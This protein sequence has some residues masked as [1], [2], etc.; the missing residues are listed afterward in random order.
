M[1]R[2]SRSRAALALAVTTALAL[3]AGC[4]SSAEDLFSHG[5]TSQ[6]GTGGSSTSSSQGGSGAVGAGGT[7][8]PGGAGGGGGTTTTTSTSSTTTTTTTTGQGGSGGGPVCP[9]ACGG[10]ESCGVGHTGLDDDCDGTVDEGC[11]CVPGTAQACFRG[12]PGLIWEPGCFTGTQL[13]Q[14]GSWGPC[15]GGVHAIDGCAL[16]E[17]DCHAI[18]TLPFVPIDLWS[19]TGAFSNGAT[20]ESFTVTCPPGVASCSPVGGSTPPDAY[21]AVRAGQYMVHYTKQSPPGSCDFPLVVRAPGLRVE[22]DWDLPGVDID[23]HV[24]EPQTTTPW[25]MQGQS[26]ADCGWANCKAQHFT[27]PM[28]SSPNWFAGV[29]PPEAVDWWLEPLFEANA[30]YFAPRNEGQT[31]QQFGQGC[32][33]PRLDID[34]ITCNAAQ[35]DLDQND[36]C[37]PEV[38]SVDYPPMGAWTRIGV[39]YYSG[40][41]TPSNAHPRVR[42]HCGGAL[43]AELGPQGYDAPV[44]FA[45]A[46]GVDPQT[47][48]LW[49]VADVRFVADPCLGLRCEVKP[50]FADPLLQTPLRTTGPAAGQTFAPP[51][52]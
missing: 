45:P 18:E 14:N 12:D 13:C 50:L 15:V 38:V 47:G 52:P 26:Q 7:T 20:G 35:T 39:H 42:V 48:V 21:R 34:T 28:A 22:L 2:S 8:N 32:H 30:C 10:S 17:P 37:L 1:L 41:Q 19:G 46:E 40:H 16:P 43:G 33:N 44:T 24:H 27:Q 25:S 9:L 3:A 49:L 31:W 5:T 4:T 6:T 36:Y 23:L 11:P 29:A 51:Y